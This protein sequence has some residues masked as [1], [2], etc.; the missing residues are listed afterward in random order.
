VA[1]FPEIPPNTVDGAL[2]R[3]RNDLPDGIHLPTRGLYKHVKLQARE[4]EGL[5]PPKGRKLKEEDFY[6]PLAD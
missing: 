3:F 5:T 6:E 4:D 2:H 1:A